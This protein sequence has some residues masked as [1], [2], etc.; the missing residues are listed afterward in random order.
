MITKIKRFIFITATTLMVAVP[1][2]LPLGI[3]AAAP[4]CNA[5]GSNIAAGATGALTTT[6]NP[7]SITC[8][9]TDTSTGSVGT[10]ANN[11]VTIFSYIVGAVSIIMIIY[12]GFR[13]V[14]SGGDQNA[15]G[16]AKNTLIYAIVG[17]VIVALA[18]LIVHFVLN[19][20]STVAQ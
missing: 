10:I 2:V 8:G 3:A 17:L 1:G 5:T 12:G 7:T 19:Q 4:N 18:Q 13:Y 6:T 16:S 15:V 9:G 11:I 20:T 14:T